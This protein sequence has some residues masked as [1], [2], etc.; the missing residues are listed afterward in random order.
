MDT[1]YLEKASNKALENLRLTYEYV[2]DR[3]AKKKDTDREE[4]AIIAIIQID[5]EKRSRLSE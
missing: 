5:G 2:R 1:S 4:R 3:S